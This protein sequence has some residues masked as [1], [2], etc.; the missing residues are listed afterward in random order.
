MKKRLRIEY[1]L[2]A[3]VMLLLFVGSIGATNFFFKKK[4]LLSKKPI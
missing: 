2:V 1:F 3:A 4:W